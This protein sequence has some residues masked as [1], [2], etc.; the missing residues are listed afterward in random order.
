MDLVCANKFQT[1]SLISAFLVTCGLAGL[2]LFAM[3][4]RLGRKLTM[5][6]SY[7]VHL[8]AQYLILFNPTYMARLIGL[9]MFGLAQMK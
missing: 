4:D 3:P 5:V 2:L 1:N 7:G 9:I 6:L 8:F